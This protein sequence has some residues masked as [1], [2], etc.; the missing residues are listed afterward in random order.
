[1]IFLINDFSSISFIFE[2]V[3]YL[4]QMLPWVSSFLISDS[5]IIL[6]KMEH[7]MVITCLRAKKLKVSSI[8]IMCFGIWIAAAWNP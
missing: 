3:K 4:L 7:R 8:R 6:I 2:E 5:Y 1:M